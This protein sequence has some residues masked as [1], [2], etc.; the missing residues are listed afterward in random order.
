[1]KLRFIIWLGCALLSTVSAMAAIQGS[2]QG[3]AYQEQGLKVIEEKCLTCHNRQRIDQAVKSRRDME[4]ILR[5]MERKGVALSDREK[6]VMGH[7]WKKN[8]LKTETK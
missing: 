6:M 7:F 8:P 2:V 5:Q 1:M 4:R 3:I